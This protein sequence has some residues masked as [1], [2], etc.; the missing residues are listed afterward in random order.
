VALQLKKTGTDTGLT[1]HGVHGRYVKVVLVETKRHIGR[2]E[3]SFTKGLCL[4]FVRHND[5]E[6]INLGK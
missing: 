3:Y 2:A 1:F 5:H 4:S 6:N